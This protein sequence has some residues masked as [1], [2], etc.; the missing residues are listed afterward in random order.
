MPGLLDKTASAQHKPSQI[1]DSDRGAWTILAVAFL[2][3]LWTAYGTFLNPDEALHYRVANKASLWLAY[4]FSLTTAHPPLLI[5]FLYFWRKIGV[6]EL[7]LRFPS[8]IAGTA[9]CWILYKWLSIRFNRNTGLIGLIF[10]GFLPPLVA[11][12]AEVRQYAFL[13]LFM[14]AATYLLDL[15]LDRESVTSMLLCH[16]CIYLAMLT[17]YSALLFTAALGIYAPLQILKRRPKA[18]VVSAW[19]VGQLVAVAL[20][21]FLYSTHISQLKSNGAASSTIEGWMRNSFYHRGHDNLLFFIIAR[22][23]GVFQFVF[24]QL[25]LGD[26]A[27]LLFAAGVVILIRKKPPKPALATFLV[28]PFVLACGAAVAGLYPYGGTRHS[29]FLSP[30]AITGVS[31]LLAQIQWRAITGRTLAL[32]IVLLSTAF[33]S[34]HRPYM[35]REDQSR[36]KMD[37]AIQAL[38]QQVPPNSVVFVDPQT[39]LQLGHYL[40]EQNLTPRDTSTA[41]F[42]SFYCGGYHVITPAS[43]DMIFDSTMFLREWD[44]MVRAFELKTGEQVYIVQAGWDIHL[45]QDLPK[46]AGFQDL[47]TESFG[48]NISMFKL[49]VAKQ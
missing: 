32:V 29:A 34:P 49:V 4:Q 37:A 48:R 7:T 35:R 36:A 2:L 18:S 6:S 41:G 24:G 26:V 5:L 15:A 22:T 47:R 44:Q 40:C 17:H 38:H 28:L 27:F 42:E 39:S 9:F 20:F 21:V 23:F 14:V 1:F 46:V 16:L 11:L 12:S 19:I 43:N 30:F 13:L 33:G 31:L 3:R 10:A 45:A 8:I 25:A